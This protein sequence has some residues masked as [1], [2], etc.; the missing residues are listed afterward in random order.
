MRVGIT[1][2]RRAEEQAELLRRQGARVA[3]GPVRRTLPLGDD[4]ALR[5]ATARV[6]EEAPS[7][8]L[9]TTG[10]G[11]RSWVGAAEA[12]GSADQLLD[13]LSA[14]RLCSRGP[15]AYAAAVQLGLTV[16]RREPTERL[17]AMVA[18][19]VDSG[20][21][22]EHVAIQLYG[23][24][25]PWAVEALERAGARVTA[26][27][28]YRWVA[29]D[30]DTRARRLVRDAIDGHLDA[31][32]FTCPSAVRN[33]CRIAEDDGT[34]D[35]LLAAF[36]DGLVACVMGPVTAEVATACCVAV[37]CAPSLGR[38]GL[39]VRALSEA[40][41]PVH[42]HLDGPSGPAL[43]KGGVVAAQGWEVELA[44]RERDVLT[45][46]ARRAGSVVGRDSLERQVWGA[47]ADRGAL[48][49]VVSRLRRTLA[50]SGLTIAT[51]VRRGYQLEAKLD[52]CPVTPGPNGPSSADPAVLGAP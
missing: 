34:L 18:S 6:I 14:A 1:A 4:E 45:A 46:L 31:V 42:L 16:W 11:V 33:L 29:P 30:D 35:P 17:D 50:P 44:D 38:L 48:D 26:V 9:L 27:P 22:G 2:D 8:V 37:G 47:T 7:I 23:E 41:R 20:V 13:V 3:F 25:V 21:E 12:W 15:K 36:R 5:S 43:L 32:T 40:L 10:I 24:P 51:R 39:M 28:I 19:L 52:R 49:A